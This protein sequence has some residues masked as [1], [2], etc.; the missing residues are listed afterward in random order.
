ME[1]IASRFVTNRGITQG[2]TRVL[3]QLNYDRR[4]SAT[5]AEVKKL[6]TTDKKTEKRV[7]EFVCNIVVAKLDR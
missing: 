4:K 5:E 3:H 7:H 6:R 1:I 2:W